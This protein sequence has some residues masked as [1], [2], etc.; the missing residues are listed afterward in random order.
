MQVRIK[1]ADASSLVYIFDPCDYKFIVFESE[2]ERFILII[3][4]M[5]T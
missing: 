1:S 4:R 2:K 3:S 5:S